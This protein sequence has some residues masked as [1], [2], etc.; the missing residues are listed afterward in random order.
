MKGGRVG[1][2]VICSNNA[3]KMAIASR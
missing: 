3:I 2:V 1:L